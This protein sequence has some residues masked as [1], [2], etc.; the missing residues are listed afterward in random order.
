MQALLNTLYVTTSGSYL[1]LDNDTVRVEVERETR[2]RV[3]LHH[4]GSVVC[5]GDS[6]VSPALLAHC[7]N[8]GISVCFLDRNGRFQ[9]RLE[10][11][12]NGNVLLRVS[13]YQHAQTEPGALTIA[14][15][16][17]AGKIR[18]SRHVLMRAARDSH[19][20]DDKRQ[21]V[22]AAKHLAA[23]LRALPQIQTLDSLRGVEG[24]AAQ[25][26]FGHFT[27]MIRPDFR[28]EFALN[29]RNRRPPQ[30]PVNALLSFV[31]TLLTHDCRSATE[32]VGLDPQVG[33]L[34]ALRPGRPALAL[35]LAEEFRAILADRLVLSLINRGQIGK[36]DF[37]PREGGA[38]WLKDDARKAVLT[39]WQQRKQEEITH[40]LLDTRMPIGLL[41]QV[42]A[43]LLARHLR[44]DLPGYL[45]YVAK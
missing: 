32:T 34:H 27:R 31:Y 7:A 3:P 35:D 42:Q 13:Q 15:N 5:M 4:L 39:A 6:L 29:G 18:N 20:D 26:Y 37:T 45:P 9:A 1:H 16:M 30:D 19:N 8:N 41:P 38:V 40:T 2:L 10:G 12:V 17:V 36:Q 44:G 14:R 25:T 33:F 43:R 28:S 24:E 23:S 21:L 22:A 11:A